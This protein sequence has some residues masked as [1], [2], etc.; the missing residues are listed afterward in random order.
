[1]SDSKIEDRL[2]V[3]ERTKVMRVGN[4]TSARAQAKGGRTS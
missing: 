2:Y 1:M 4:P 3:V